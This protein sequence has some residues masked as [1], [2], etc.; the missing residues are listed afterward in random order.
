L[1]RRRAGTI[2]LGVLVAFT[3]ALPVRGHIVYGN[4][5]LYQLTAGSD[6]VARARIEDPAGYLAPSGSSTR[7]P[8][9]AANL[10][11]VF[12]GPV[13]LGPV[14]FAQHG[15]GVASYEVGE[16]VLL[17]LLEIE[18]SRE[19]AAL[20]ETSNLRYVSLQEDDEK[21]PLTPES[22]V[23][24]GPVIQAYVRIEKMSGP[25][26][27][28]RALGNLTIRLL[29]SPR[30]RIAASA[31]RDVVGMGGELLTE[32]NLPQVEPLIDDR[33]IA[34]GIRIGLLAELERLRL[35]A[36]QPRWARLLRT[37]EVPDL[38]AV[39]RA[40][41][42]HPGPE[43][44]AELVRLLRAEEPE[45]VKAAA[46]SLGVPGNQ[47]AVEPLSRLLDA[48]DSS[49]RMAAIRGL[50]RIATPEARK[51]LET[52]ARSHPDAATRRRARAEVTIG[53]GH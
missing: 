6:L 40:A 4:R 46:I 11:E 53:A 33:N 12:K 35:V 38:L 24:F 43:V 36:G 15:H 1:K 17:F 50:G 7:R 28:A 8:V 23:D 49:V 31:L 34:I 26:E 37:A 22:R 16:E 20:A 10:L 18:H 44:T 45:T 47:K 27:R 32:R 13:A 29:R 39:V 19:L 41:G 9:V 42:S 2:L 5:S 3:P 30:K 25:E 48:A 21:Y 14:R 51:V 52:T